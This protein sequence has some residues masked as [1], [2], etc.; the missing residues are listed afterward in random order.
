MRT[1]PAHAGEAHC[2]NMCRQ[3]STFKGIKSSDI[4]CKPNQNITSSPKTWIDSLEHSLVSLK[5]LDCFCSR[6][7]YLN[8][9][10]TYYLKQGPPPTCCLLSVITQHFPPHSFL[11]LGTTVTI[12]TT[13]SNTF[14]TTTTTTASY[15]TTTATYTAT[16][17][18][19]T[20][21]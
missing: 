17:S 7:S 1:G 9:A 20:S 12:T 14:N 18:T 13:T 4:W 15:T 2:L 11:P 5:A 16:T 19:T 21:M 3:N 6:C 8:L 10:L